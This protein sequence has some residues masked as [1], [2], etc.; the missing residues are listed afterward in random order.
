[1]KRSTLIIFLALF[2][3]LPALVFAQRGSTPPQGPLEVRLASF[4]PRNSDWGR[5]L[6]RIAAEW[7]KVT[8]NGV[9][10]RIIHDGVEGGEQKTLSSLSAGNIQAAL[11]TSFGLSNICPSV[12]TLSVPFCIRNGVEMEL[13]FQDALPFLETQINRTNF[14]VLAWS[15]ANWINIFSKDPVFVPD[16]LRRHRVATNPDSAEL[17]T[18]FKVMGFHLIETEITDMGPK[19][20]N[21]VINAVYQTP[22]AVAPL[23]LHKNLKNMLDMPLAPFMGAIVINRVTWNRISPAHQRELLR[24]TQQIA[25][26]FDTTMPRTAASALSAMQK[27]GLKVNKLSA[28]QEQLWQTEI[29]K[30]MPSL[31]GSTFDPELYA[32]INE[33]LTK[34]RSGR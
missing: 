6:D 28:A 5:C 3:L 34:S 33:T 11:F 23:G 14:M 25:K 30:A 8:N 2:S 20:A 15:K 18:A 17:N 27:D 16:D 29:Q 9:R 4:M 7:A 1:M 22:A 32:K 19:L 13:V 26:E 24:V 10:L 21:N 31:F 12:M